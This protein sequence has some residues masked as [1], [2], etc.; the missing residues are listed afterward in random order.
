MKFYFALETLFMKLLAHPLRGIAAAY[1]IAKGL[2]ILL[3]PGGTALIVESLS[4]G[5]INTAFIGAAFI[6]AGL[7]MV[8]ARRKITMLLAIVVEVIYLAMSSTSFLYNLRTA[9][10]F[11]NTPVAV[12]QP[13]AIVLLCL[14]AL[15]YCPADEH[16]EPVV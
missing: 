14:S 7:A 4:S 6:L 10:G 9:G 3:F 2:S 12:L 1:F 16:G 11:S 15:L 8:L 5:W 13:L